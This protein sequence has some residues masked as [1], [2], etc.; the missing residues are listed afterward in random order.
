MFGLDAT[1][2]LCPFGIEVCLVVSIR[3]GGYWRASEASETPSGLFNRESRYVYIRLIT[4]VRVEYGELFYEYRRIFTSRRRVQMQLLSE[5]TS[6]Y[7]TYNRH[8]RD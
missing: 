4:R 2:V 5:I 8:L 1:P 6:P 3:G 7:S